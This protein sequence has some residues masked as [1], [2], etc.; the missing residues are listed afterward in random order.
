[1]PKVKALVL[2]TAGLLLAL[3]TAA[4]AQDFPTRPIRLLVPFTPGGSVDTVARAL[5]TRLGERLGRQVIVDNR[6]GASGIIA[7][8]IAVKA[9]ADGHTLLMISF[10]HAVS[11]WMY[12]KL[13]YNPR[14]DFVPVT[15]LAKGVSLLSIHPSVPANSVKELVALARS[16][17]KELHF[18]NAGSG[19]YT[20]VSSAL[21][22][23]MAGIDIVHVPF[24]G[25]GPA[26]TDVIGGHTQVLLNSIVTALPHVRSGRLK[27]LGISDTKRSPLLPDLPTVDEAGVP[28]YE[29][30]NWWGV[31]IAAGTPPAIVERLHREIAAVQNSDDMKA[32]F[33]KD[34]ATPMQLSAAES[35][36]FFLSE[37]EKWGKV[38]KAANI[39]RQ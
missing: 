21:F 4:A 7:T 2:K 18:A 29:A 9:P 33:A 15:M 30:T 11:P 8:E 34:G 1:M 5:A 39:Q 10:T 36:R 24:K 26:M 19:T 12:D 38:V 3:T 20:H 17:P 25:T 37:M 32:Q 23:M 28:G 31:A 27:A 13:P 14:R 22:A 6:S 35:G 16:K